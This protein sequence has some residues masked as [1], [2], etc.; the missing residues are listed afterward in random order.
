MIA[1]L[2][3]IAL[4]GIGLGIGMILQPWWAGGFRIGFFA[5]IVFT[6]GHIVT[7]HIGKPEAQ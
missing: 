7:A 5:T 1:T 2:N 3:R 4:A 6:V